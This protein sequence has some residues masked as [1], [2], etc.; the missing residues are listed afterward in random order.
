MKLGLENTRNAL[1]MLGNPQKGLNII[2]VAGTNGKGTVCALT[3]SILKASDKRV[4]LYISPHL[5]DLKERISI[6]SKLISEE[7]LVDLIDEIRTT[8]E[9]ESSP[10]IKLTFFEFLTVAAVC[11][12]SKNNVDFAVMETGLGG[13]F[14]ATNALDSRIAII[15][16]VGI[17]HMKHLG[18]G[19][20]SIAM[21]K[22]GII[23][24]GV[25]VIS[26]AIDSAAMDVIRK[27]A[28]ETGSF[29]AEFGKDFGSSNIRCDLSGTIFDYDGTRS[30]K[31]V[32]MSLLGKVQAENCATAI[33]ACDILARE[34]GFV[35]SDEHIRKGVTEL[36]WHGRLEIISRD[37]LILI[38]SGHN[39]S[40]IRKTLESM[41]DIG[42]DPKTIVYASSRDKDF[43][44][45]LEM[46]SSNAK[47]IVLTKY[48]N[49]R[50]IDPSII[51][52]L[53]ENGKIEVHLTNDASEAMAK[54]KLV[55]PDQETILVIGSIFLTGE[56]LS[57]DKFGEYA[58]MRMAGL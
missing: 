37:P 50:A 18:E 41:K 1:E 3:A 36:N 31:G 16:Q 55:T 4:G 15:T 47:R 51:G 7:N 45:I 12:F 17:D 35:L 49:K 58:D 39:P 29:L 6:N 32:K 23:R 33:A 46:L 19:I 44:Q 26:S 56:V 13:R 52:G 40:A 43:R 10:Q 8:V 2:H 9:D 20:E 22:A 34:M 24:E 38:D 27:R 25:S 11:Y 53:I 5:I 54:A 48:Q 30:M 28:S 57:L 21:E 42:K 14:D